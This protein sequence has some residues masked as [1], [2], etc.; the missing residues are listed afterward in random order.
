MGKAMIV[1]W[2]TIDEPGSS[3]VLYWGKNSKQ[4]RQA[5]GKTVTYKFYNY[6]SGFIHHCTIRNLKVISTFYHISG[7][8]RRFMISEIR[9][10]KK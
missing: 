2:V 9:I 1:S 8:V 7:F 6:T 3:T 4:K 10:A 5:E